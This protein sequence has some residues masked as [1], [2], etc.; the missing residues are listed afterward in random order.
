MCLTPK[1]IK[2][3]RSTAAALVYKKTFNII[4]QSN[5]NCTYRRYFNLLENFLRRIPLLHHDL[6]ITVGDFNWSIFKF[7]SRRMY[8]RHFISVIVNFK[9]CITTGI[10]RTKSNKT[11][12]SLFSHFFILSKY[13]NTEM[14][15]TLNI[16][17]VT[18]QNK[19]IVKVINLKYINKQILT[20]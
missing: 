20:E 12:V 4:S 9:I 11:F 2:F 7:H 10:T 14:S 13:K 18:N 3:C 19:K 6:N 15:L 1:K 5:H 16:S 17:L 8:K